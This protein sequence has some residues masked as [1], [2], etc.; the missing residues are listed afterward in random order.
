VVVNA[1]DN[2][3]SILKGNGDR[4]FQAAITIQVGANPT[5]LAL[6]DFNGDGKPDIAVTDLV[7][8]NVSILINQSTPGTINFATPVNY[9]VATYPS[10]VV[11]AD[12]NHDGK[13][14]LAIVCS[15]Y[16][17]A[18]T[19]DGKRT[20]LS[21]LLGNGDGTFQPATTQ[22]LW[23]QTGGDAIVA[24]DFG[25]GQTDLAVVNFSGQVMIL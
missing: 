3:L 19:D 16:F 24:A 2:T 13:P 9:A 20:N 15:G 7:D 12:F 23:Y 18:S 4:T 22:Q 6:G 17:F 1:F 10:G 11:T 8:N 14:D 21:I 25:R 5:S